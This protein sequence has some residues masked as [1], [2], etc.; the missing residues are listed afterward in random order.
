M[1]GPA[2]SVFS[3]LKANPMSGGGGSTSGASLE[4]AAC[5]ARIRSAVEDASPILW[6]ISR[7][8]APQNWLSP[9]RPPTI[10][11][12]GNPSHRLAAPGRKRVPITVEPGVSLERATA[13]SGPATTRSPSIQVMSTQPSGTTADK[14]PAS[15]RNVLDQ[16]HRKCLS[17]AAG[18][19]NSRYSPIAPERT[20]VLS[21]DVTS[22]SCEEHFLRH[23]TLRSPK[24]IAV[25]AC[26][27]PC[28]RSRS[29]PA[30]HG[31]DAR[32][33]WAA[34]LGN[35]RGFHQSW[36]GRERSRDL[37]ACAARAIRPTISHRLPHDI[38]FTIPM[39]A[40][41]CLA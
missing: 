26:F 28:C 5:I 12:I 9:T 15:G 38:I 25:A 18:G 34:E 24:S 16:T 27:N 36:S 1:P 41:G 37:G 14:L 2:D 29:S 4:S 13:T 7:A 20:G 32:R 23:R 17:S 6:A 33:N 30:S 11:D 19:S 31:C 10:S 39:P 35:C 22:L 8:S 3:E 21:S 40:E